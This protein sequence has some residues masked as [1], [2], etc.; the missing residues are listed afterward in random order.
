MERVLLELC[1]QLR[2]RTLTGFLQLAHGWL[3]THTHTT[4]PW[5]HS[6]A[7]HWESGTSIQP[8]TLTT[9]HNLSSSTS[10]NRVGLDKL[11]LAFPILALKRD[12]LSL[13]TFATIV[14]VALVLLLP[15]LILGCRFDLHPRI[16][17]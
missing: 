16:A 4:G 15:T 6:A 9:P 12:L 13:S 17:P 5:V 11:F 2:N 8:P 1:R 14:G 7:R 3:G 10:L